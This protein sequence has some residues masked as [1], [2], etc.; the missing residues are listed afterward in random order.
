MRASAMRIIYGR[1]WI[2]AA[3]FALILMLDGVRAYL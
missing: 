2:S 3:L 1:L